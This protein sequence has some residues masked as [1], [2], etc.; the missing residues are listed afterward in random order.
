M[1]IIGKTTDGF[2]GELSSHEVARLTGHYGMG[3]AGAPADLKVGDTIQID[4]M[5]D[6]LYR[7]Q[8]V[9]DDL[10]EAAKRLRTA[11]K[12]ADEVCPVLLA[13]QEG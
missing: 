13:G 2:I 8:M 10:A 9:K 12:C 5:W 11:A 6:R 3:Q 1:K 4:A 7:L